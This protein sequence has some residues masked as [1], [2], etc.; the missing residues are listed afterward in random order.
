MSN[1]EVENKKTT[2]V[3]LEDNFKINEQTQWQINP[4]QNWEST[5]P[6][7]KWIIKYQTCSEIKE[8]ERTWRGRWT[9]KD[10]DAERE[11]R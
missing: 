3:N 7:L 9:Q 11:H 10:G 1:S 5:S 4:T 2:E 8:R 6:H